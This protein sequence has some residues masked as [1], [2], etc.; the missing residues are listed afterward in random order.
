MRAPEFWNR[1]RPTDRLLASAL[2]PAGWIYGASVAYKAAHA[3]PYRPSAKL[4]CVG[5]LTAGGTGKTPVA[6]AVARTLAGRGMHPYFLT[7]GYGGANRAARVVNPRTDIAAEVGDEALL[8][9]TA[10]PVIVSRD[11]AEGARLAEQNGAEVIVMDDGHQNFS[12]AKDL[13]LVVVDAEQ[14]FGNGRV[15][16]AGPLRE[17][18][19][20]GLARAD[21]MIL[22]GDGTPAELDLPRPILRA[23][24]EVS[25][26]GGLRGQ[27]VLAFA[28][29]GHPKKFFRTLRGIGAEIVGTRSFPDHHRYSARELARL[30]EH[31]QA[32]S[33]LLVT[34]EKDFVRLAPSDRKDVLYLPVSAVFEDEDAFAHLLDRIAPSA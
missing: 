7:R 26:A 9:A 25:D 21:A 29:I 14:G 5:N 32:K 22:M 16:P 20:Q 12:L 2:A 34:T 6:I 3:R 30:R 23:R 8:L 18:V 15:I 10:A 4:I 11:R 28:G 19:A 33:A 31:A 17:P 13:S 27:R 24:F 1:K